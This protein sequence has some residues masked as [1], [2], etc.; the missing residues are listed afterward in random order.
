MGQMMK[1]QYWPVTTVGQKYPTY[2]D[3]QFGGGG[4]R[5]G[6]SGGRFGRAYNPPLG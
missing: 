6:G 3:Y 5:F 4:S 2:G 1:A